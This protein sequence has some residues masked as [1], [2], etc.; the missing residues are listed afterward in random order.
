M[1][2][3]L[4]LL[5]ASFC[6]PL[7]SQATVIVTPTE[8]GTILA[9]NLAG[10]G[11]SIVGGSESLSNNSSAIASGTFTGGISA[12]IGIDQG[13]ILTTGEAASAAGP[14]Q[15]DSTSGGGNQTELSF[16]FTTDTGDLFFSYVWASE[17]YNE[18]V[19]SQFNDTFSLEVDGVNVALIPGTTT[20]VQI[21]TVNNGVNS[22]F[23]N[24]NDPSNG[25]PTPF[26]IEY[27][28][29]TSVFTAEALGLAPG[30]HSISFKVNDVGD[31][32]YDSAVF[33][34]A[35]SFS[36]NS[37]VPDGGGTLALLGLAVAG[38]RFVT[39]RN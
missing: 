33:I 10:P 16:D 26:D 20:P 23:Y 34:K 3:R 32:S 8:D 12:G 7:A 27:D 4:N 36:G 6:L 30:T 18:Y 21:N 22:G 31:S 5:L 9:S 35:G 29:F 39:K 14:N 1:N 28:G 24:D 25:T 15:S 19:N 11:I 17:E 38:L 37:P 2:K 13:I